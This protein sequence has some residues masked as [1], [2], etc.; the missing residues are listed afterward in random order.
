MA[1]SDSQLIDKAR[2]GDAEAFGL[3]WQRHA[4]AAHWAA[5][6]LVP[7][8]DCEDVVQES[9]TRL[10]TELQDS[11]SG[12]VSG[13]FR[14]YVYV[15]VRHVAQ[16][17]TVHAE[18]PLADAHSLVFDDSFTDTFVEHAMVN[19]AYK[20]LSPQ[21]QSIL[22]YTEVE[23]LTPV[24]I[25]PL[26][27]ISANAVSALAYRAREG[28]R[29]SWLQAHISASPPDPACEWTVERLGMYARGTLSA[30][31]ATKIDAHL[32]R[33]EDCT[34]LL[35]EVNAAADQL[36]V[37]ALATVLGFSFAGITSPSL[38]VG[39]NAFSS[40]ASTSPVP[41][42]GAHIGLAGARGL[43]NVAGFG[44]VPFFGTVAASIAL[45]AAGIAVF[46][47]QDPVDSIASGTYSSTTS[48]TPV[49][50]TQVPTGFFGQTAQFVASSQN[51]K[52]DNVVPPRSTQGQSVSNQGAVSQGGPNGQ[53]TPVNPQVPSNQDPG[54]GST[55]DPS[56]SGRE[57]AVPP[58]TPSGNPS[59]Q[60][61]DPE[62]PT[63]PESPSTPN[64]P[65]GD[66][67]TTPTSTPTSTPSE[68]P[69]ETE[70]EYVPVFFAERIN[71]SD[72]SK[73]TFGGTGPFYGEVTVQ[74]ESDT[75]VG[76]VVI[77]GD[78]RWSVTLTDTYTSAGRTS[79]TY[80]LYVSENGAAPQLSATITATGLG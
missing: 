62:V 43:T 70:P 12:S 38:S 49:T 58:S 61:G 48:D 13:P 59:T 10:F 6:R 78:S 32:D 33:C 67:S 55:G 53:G 74:D 41:S 77:G 24:E 19:Q 39:T 80:R 28:L 17:T 50:S 57:P 75:V 23:E 27:G 72:P 8:S 73:V 1:L 31:S 30:R 11:A 3:L 79:M 15:M 68:N 54:T 21:W 45:L 9:F 47:T 42:G 7:G 14:Q 51:V 60:S 16:A 65:S 69:S 76:R 5:E 34:L 2:T 44:S 63:A 29:A 46:Q 25:A 64:T 52:F 56:D 35:A 20:S 37:S 40:L 22:W 36:R 4:T 18:S 66:P 26:L 71:L